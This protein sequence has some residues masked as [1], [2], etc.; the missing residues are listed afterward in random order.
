MPLGYS[1]CDQFTVKFVL[2]GITVSINGAL[3]AVRKQ[4]AY[5]RNRFRKLKTKTELHLLVHVGVLSEIVMI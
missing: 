1:G 2:P 3:G 4:N 5:R